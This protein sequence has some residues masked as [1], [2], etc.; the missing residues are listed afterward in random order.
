ML[1]AIVVVGVLLAL[2]VGGFLAYGPIAEN[3]KKA[4]VKSVASAIH[5]AVLV[6]STDGD[7]ATHPQDV[8]EDWNSTT[9]K[10]RVEILETEAGLAAM[11]TTVPSP[12]ANGDFCVQAT[13]L[14]SPH[15]TAR[16][17]ACDDVI[18][19]S[20][21]EDLPDGGAPDT[22]GDGIPDVTD[23]DIDGNGTP[24]TPWE[25]YSIV[26]DSQASGGEVSYVNAGDGGTT[27]WNYDDNSTYGHSHDPVSSRLLTSPQ[28]DIL[29]V[30]G[31]D[32]VVTVTIGTD[33][34][35]DND[36]GAVGGS[37]AVWLHADFDCINTTTN[38][39]RH[40]YSKQG[41]SQLKAAYLGG[42]P[43]PS[44]GTLAWGCSGGERI[45][46][47]VLRPISQAEWTDLYSRSFNFTKNQIVHWSR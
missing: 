22:D 24:N 34:S 6:A 46:N 21:P 15:I 33:G 4:K 23:P 8:I 2:A 30:T 16:E 37:F 40:D 31:S 20:N 19:G 10:I 26:K 36:S 5:T 38:A 43:P 27:T 42:H 39:V 45:N 25:S 47:F 7:T 32:Q 9:D 1:E 12:S 11:T 3:A 28:L 41:S 14:E 35:M 13:N 18:D 29:R 44:T 17:G